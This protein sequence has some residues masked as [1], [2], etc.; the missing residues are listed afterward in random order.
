VTA[1]PIRTLLALLTLIAAGFALAQAIDEAEILAA[2]Q[3]WGDGI[4]AIGRAYSSGGDYTAVAADHIRSLY[5]YGSVPVAFKPTKAAAVP[6]RPTFEDAL[7]YFV[8]GHIPEDQG[9]ALAPYVHVEFANHAVVTVGTFAYAMGSY[10]FRDA[11]GHETAVEY[12]FGYVRDAE[13]HLRIALHHS[14][15]PYSPH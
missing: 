3:Q 9:F 13:G 12:T 7:S 5:A 4:V 2:Q 15:L 6:F 10:T 14:S 1:A 8:G 11:N